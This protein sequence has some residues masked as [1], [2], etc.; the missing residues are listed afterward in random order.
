MSEV[1]KLEINMET[2]NGYIRSTTEFRAGQVVTDMRCK[3]EA[4]RDFAVEIIKGY[5][6]EHLGIN[7]VTVTL[8]DPADGAEYELTIRKDRGKTPAQVLG[9]QKAELAQLRS[10]IADLRAKAQ[11]QCAT[12]H[13]ST[14]NEGAAAMDSTEGLA[15]AAERLLAELGVTEPGAGQDNHEMP[16]AGMMD[17]LYTAW[18]NYMRAK[19]GQADAIFEPEG[20]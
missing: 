12:S 8:T 20:E 3:D 13:F 2:A 11:E 17:A 18:N 9:E 10:E 7:F 1:K 15:L 14:P 19:H 5:F 16:V 4:F 6:T